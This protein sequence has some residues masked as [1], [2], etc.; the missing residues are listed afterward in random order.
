MKRRS[1]EYYTKKVPSDN[2]EFF[3]N[4]VDETLEAY[5]AWKQK[6]ADYYI[7]NEKLKR[8]EPEIYKELINTDLSDKEIKMLT[9]VYYNE[10]VI[11]YSEKLISDEYDLDS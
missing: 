4:S 3:F 6:I 5:K 9:E 10:N 2:T 8:N 1:F 11:R 7:T